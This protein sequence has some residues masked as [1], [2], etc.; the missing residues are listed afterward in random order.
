[1]LVPGFCWYGWAHR[2]LR[3]WDLRVGAGT[4]H[5]QGCASTW[6]SC[7]GDFS[8]FS[9]KGRVGG[10][11]EE[12]PR[13]AYL[14]GVLVGLTWGTVNMFGS[15]A[16]SSVLGEHVCQQLGSLLS[17]QSSRPA[18]YPMGRPHLRRPICRNPALLGT[19]IVNGSETEVLG[20]VVL[21]PQKEYIAGGKWLLG[22]L[23]Q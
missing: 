18:L 3:M 9:I 23:H 2:G 7:P 19:G 15:W 6:N 5:P 12:S 22:D 13:L 14:H 21:G 1:M 20:C 10:V 4:W 16:R 11:R 17:R 8:T